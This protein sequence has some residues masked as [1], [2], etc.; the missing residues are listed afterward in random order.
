MDVCRKFARRHTLGAEKAS[1]TLTQLDVKKTRELTVRDIDMHHQDVIV[2]LVRGLKTQREKKMAMDYILGAL[3]G[4]TQEPEPTEE[5]DQMDE[6]DLED[7]CKIY[8]PR[9]VKPQA[10]IPLPW[11]Y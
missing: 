5:E 11:L 3:H 4:E 9:P 2:R 8:A 7:G 10:I 6:D 1:A